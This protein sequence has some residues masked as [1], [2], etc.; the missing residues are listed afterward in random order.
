MGM[1]VQLTR[2]PG[3]EEGGPV[4]PVYINIY[5]VFPSQVPLPS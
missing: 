2:A 4:D 5:R 3:P 1:T